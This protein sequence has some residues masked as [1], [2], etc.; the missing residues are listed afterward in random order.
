MTSQYNFPQGK[1][2]MISDAE[3]IRRQIEL[4]GTTPYGP[5][6][7]TD[8]KIMRALM[9]LSACCADQKRLLDGEQSIRPLE[10][11]PNPLA[12]FNNE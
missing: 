7:S 2:A 6:E 12:Y 10:S 4:W 5:P 3:R 1:I 9:Q 8:I 11:Y